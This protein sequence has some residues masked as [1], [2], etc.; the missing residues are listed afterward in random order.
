MIKLIILLDKF[1]I[2]IIK[3]LIKFNKFL[4]LGLKLLRQSLLLADQLLELILEFLVLTGQ[5]LVRFLLLLNT[6]R[7]FLHAHLNLEQ[8]GV[9]A[10]DLFLFG[11]LVSFAL[12]NLLSVVLDRVVEVPDL[13]VE[14]LALFAFL[15]E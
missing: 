7:E 8:V 11:I 15:L 4:N 10:E 14:S 3:V 6:L 1:D 5:V 12:L 9:Q 13:R 2:L